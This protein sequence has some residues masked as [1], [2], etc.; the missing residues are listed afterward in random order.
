M[1]LQ[2]SVLQFVETKLLQWFGHVKIMEENWSLKKILEWSEL[3]K[4]RNHWY[5]RAKGFMGEWL[6]SYERLELENQ[7][8]LG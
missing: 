2:N 7:Y 3:L 1:N 5:D 8:K 4:N 6:K